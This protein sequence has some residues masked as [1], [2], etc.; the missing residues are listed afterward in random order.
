MIYFIEKIHLIDIYLHVILSMIN[1][2]QQCPM[3]NFY[4]IFETRL[5]NKFIFSYIYDSF[6]LTFIFSFSRVFFLL[7][8]L[9]FKVYADDE[10]LYDRKRKSFLSVLN[11]K[12]VYEDLNLAK[13]ESFIRCKYYLFV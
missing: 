4:V 11:K 8:L 10:I 6:F 2:N 9:F 12:I 5:A 3:Q 7:L 1:L 13:N